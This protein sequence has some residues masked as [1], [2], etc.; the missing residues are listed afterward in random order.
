MAG[1]WPALRALLL[2]IGRGGNLVTDAWIAAAVQSASGRL[3]TLDRDFLQRLPP[4]DPT[5]LAA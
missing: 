4:R 1:D 3:V 2:R 5:V